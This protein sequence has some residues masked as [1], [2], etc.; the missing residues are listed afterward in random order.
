MATFGSD[1]V[2][3]FLLGGVDIL[4]TLTTIT[5]KQTAI[6]EE[7][8]TLGDAWVENTYV[9]VKTAE[10]SQDGFFYAGSSVDTDRVHEALS[11]G[12][13]TSKILMFNHEGNVAGKNFVGWAGALQI[14]QQIAVERG[15]LTKARVNYKVGPGAV[16]EQGKILRAL[17]GASATGITSGSAVD[18]LSSDTSGGAAYLQVTA[19]TTG[20][21]ST[22]LK[23]DVMHSADNLT[24]ASWAGFANVS[25][26]PN[27][28]R[29]AS[30][31]PLQRYGAVRWTGDA[32]SSFPTSAVFVAGLVRRL[33]S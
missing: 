14:D 15:A 12:L 6:V 22:A 32:A 7:S 17:A 4:G 21:P 2:G 20:G 13:A 5:D 33:T 24:F 27:A 11:T 16:V 10:L 28:Q 26:A 23:V 1:K 29:I 18:F 19:F 3:F 30:T 9:G 31:A 8:H 25:A